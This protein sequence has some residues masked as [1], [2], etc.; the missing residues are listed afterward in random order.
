M[1]YALLCV[2]LI[3]LTSHS[4]ALAAVDIFAC[5]PEWK[6][7]AEEIGGDK[8][9]AYTATTAFQDPHHIEARPSLIAR[10]RSADLLFCTGA[11]LEVG[12]LPLLLR[13]SGNNNIQIG[14]PGYLM[15]ADH[16]DKIEVPDRVD[17]SQGDVHASGNPH[18]H[19]DPRRLLIIADVLAQRLVQI[20]AD[21][22]DFYRQSLSSFRQRWQQAISVW[23]RDAKDLRGKK[24]VIHHRNLS[25]LFDWLGLVI[26]A[27]LEPKPG[28]P[29]TSSHLVS[30]LQHIK[31]SRPDMIVLA[32]YQNPR[33]AQW[34]KKRTALPVVT[35]PYTVGGNRQS[36]DLYSLFDSTIQ[37]LAAAKG[38]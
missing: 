3:S 31:Q 23:E 24:L 13:Q 25:Y 6:A 32:A 28:L 30:L 10:A 9:S 19:L 33:G 17:R 26:V 21:N 7:L 22:G 34:L 38:G 11:E 4:L 2:A 8:V 14:K 18:V 37:L 1:K 35:V 5:E 27:D 15:A 16:V 29:P 12:W 36:G 20:D